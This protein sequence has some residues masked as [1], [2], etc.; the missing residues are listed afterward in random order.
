M[1]EGDV[2]RD[3]ASEA[4]KAFLKELLPKVLGALKKAG[5]LKRRHLSKEL[6]ARL[7]DCVSD[8]RACFTPRGSTF[9]Y[10]V[11]NLGLQQTDEWR[12][13]HYRLSMASAW[14]EGWDAMQRAVGERMTPEFFTS[15]LENLNRLLFWTSHAGEGL[16]KLVEQTPKNDSIR[17]AAHAL[18]DRYNAFL[19]NYEGFLRRLP[20]DI[21]MSPLAPV[22][23]MEHFFGR[24][25]GP[26]SVPPSVQG[27][28]D[29]SWVKT[30]DPGVA[31]AAR[32]VL[33]EVK[34]KMD[35]MSDP[36]VISAHGPTAGGFRL[37]P[38]DHSHAVR[39]REKVLDMLIGRGVLKSAKY[40]NSEDQVGRWRDG[41][42]VIA[43]REPVERTLEALN[44]RPSR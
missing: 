37:P 12:F 10:V 18:T 6:P 3:V 22:K 38:A 17:K 19:T 39:F 20:A 2:F 9:T 5:L 7:R 43:D 32:R 14:F 44:E 30:C 36:I 8:L 41:F 24:L 34:Q 29:T 15:C 23:G 42:A 25:G 27:D 16:G 4:A 11:E 31:R 35:L 21:G 26:P 40:F 33:A 13:V 1:H 28:T